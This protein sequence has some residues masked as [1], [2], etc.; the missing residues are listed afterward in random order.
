[1]KV[2]VGDRSQD[3]LLGACCFDGCCG[4]GSFCCAHALPHEHDDEEFE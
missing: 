3:P 1:M 4:P 2:D